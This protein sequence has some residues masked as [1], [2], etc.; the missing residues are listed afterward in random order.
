MNT[1]ESTR[2]FNSWANGIR[3]SVARGRLLLRI[4]SATLGNLGDSKHLRNGLFEMRVHVG[5]G[6]RIYYM[7]TGEMSYLLLTGGDKSTQA[8]DI[9]RALKMVGRLKTG[10][11]A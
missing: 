6:Y 3:D 7:R 8:R 1:F 4:R 11:K 10:E 5:P 2:E 9:D